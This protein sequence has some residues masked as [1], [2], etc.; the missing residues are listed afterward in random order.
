M[1]YFTADTHFGHRWIS[2]KRGFSSTDEHDNY[3]IDKWNSIVKPGD[4]TYILGDLTYDWENIGSILQRLNGQKFLIIGNHDRINNRTKPILE[5]HFIWIKNYFV[6]K[7]KNGANI[8]S[9]KIVLSH[10]PF[11]VWD[12]QHYGTFHFYGHVHGDCQ[13]ITM[14]R[15]ANRWDV[16][17]DNNNYYPVMFDDILGKMKEEKLYVK[18]YRD[19]LDIR[20]AKNKQYIL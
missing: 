9:T 8:P 20:D 7:I 1:K 11:E 10:Y 12:G 15:V 13:H 14:S 6:V 4:E 18:D 16:G 5:K 17:V 2:K 19:I 3:I